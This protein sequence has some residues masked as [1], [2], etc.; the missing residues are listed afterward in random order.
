VKELTMSGWESGY[1]LSSFFVMI[2]N[3]LLEGSALINMDR[4]CFDYTEAYVERREGEEDGG[5][6]RE[7]RVFPYVQG[8]RARETQKG[9]ERDLDRVG[10]ERALL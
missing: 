8:T 7:G 3:L 2:R 4:A 1:E 6:R 10:K 5:S 9:E